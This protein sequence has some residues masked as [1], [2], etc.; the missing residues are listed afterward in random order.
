MSVNPTPAKRAKI[1]D[2]DQIAPRRQVVVQ[3]HH[4]RQQLCTTRSDYRR[5]KNETAVKAFSI[6]DEA[7]YLLVHNV[8]KM[9]GVDSHQEI[10]SLCPNTNVLAIEPVQYETT[11]PF[12]Q[13][14]LVK[15][16]R[17]VDARKAKNKLDNYVLLGSPLHVCYAPEFETA[18]T[19]LAKI[20]ERQ[21]FVGIK[22]AQFDNLR[23]K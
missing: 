18:E 8:P 13:V 20:K 4:I 17:I 11:N 16:G 10:K 9:S 21:R 23:F 15:Y 1:S 22:L 6:A 5:G 2:S 14:F 3:Q 7:T 12:T 19:T